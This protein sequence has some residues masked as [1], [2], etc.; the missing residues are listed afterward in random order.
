M[1]RKVLAARARADDAD[2]RI[3][4]E[5]A[6]A[7]VSAE[8]GC[9][10]ETV[11]AA[12]RAH[13]GTLLAEGNDVSD[14]AERIIALREQA[15]TQVRGG[16]LTAAEETARQA[17]ALSVAEHGA[18]AWPTIAIYAQLAAIHEAQ[19]RWTGAVA[20]YEQEIARTERR[21]GARHLV[22]ARRLLAY[23]AALR[24]VGRDQE[25]REAEIRGHEI[26]AGSEP[27]VPGI[28]DP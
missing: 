11:V 19:D 6:I 4:L 23:A 17:L 9:P 12:W 7:Q 18:D 8:T 2:R 15:M 13:R 16:D 25:A 28:R 21:L 3:M 1:A 20:A 27:E 5:T 24:K 14:T 22:L 10:A 26:Y